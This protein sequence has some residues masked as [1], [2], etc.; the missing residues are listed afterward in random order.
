MCLF[1]F[2]IDTQNI[3]FRNPYKP[4]SHK[5]GHLCAY[6]VNMLTL[7]WNA[8]ARKCTRSCFS[9]PTHSPPPQM[10]K[11]PPIQPVFMRT[12]QRKHSSSKP[13]SPPKDN[14]VPI[15]NPSAAAAT[16]ATSR[17]DL[18][19][20]RSTSTSRR[21]AKE[22]ALPLDGDNRDGALWDLP[23]VPSTQYLTHNG[24]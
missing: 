22:V 9:C 13:S 20:R 10:F 23:S 18:P 14:T 15:S 5:V 7:N 4:L 17:N 8:A 21:K 1:T 3:I 16:K 24:Q 2:P 11:A 12:H 6:R 19:K